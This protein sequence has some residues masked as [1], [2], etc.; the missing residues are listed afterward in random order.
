M[1]GRGPAFAGFCIIVAWVDPVSEK[2]SRVLLK[3]LS[4]L[5][6][7]KKAAQHLVGGGLG[8]ILPFNLKLRHSKV[9][10]DPEK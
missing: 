3:I 4:G 8:E 10:S 7:K 2:N 5:S 6:V 1:V 9:G